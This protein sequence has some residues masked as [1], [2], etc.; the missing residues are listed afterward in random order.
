M[1]ARKFLELYYN[2]EKP[3]FPIDPFR[4]LKDFGILFMFW[5][6]KKLE[7]IY[8]SP[9]ND[10]DIAVIGINKNRPIFRQRYTAAHELCHHI[11]D[12]NVQ[13]VCPVDGNK[14]PTERFAEDFAAA[15]LM[16]LDELEE[17]VKVYKNNGFVTLDDVLYIAD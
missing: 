4:M 2:G 1:L 14:N 7:G 9:E 5:D 16:P 17:Q 13:N 6:L 10:E 15:L 12:K 11:K 3:S 8:I